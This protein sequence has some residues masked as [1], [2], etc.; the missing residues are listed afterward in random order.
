MSSIP[1]EELK[2]LLIFNSMMVKGL[3]DLVAT[4]KIPLER[5]ELLG[6]KTEEIISQLSFWIERKNYQRFYIELSMHMAWVMD[7]FK[8]DLKKLK[9]KDV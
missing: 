5:L 2:N 9:N 3:T 8:Q 1:D 4:K 6:N 7:N